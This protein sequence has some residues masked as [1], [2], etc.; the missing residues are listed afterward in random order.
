MGFLNTRIL[1]FFAGS[2]LMITKEGELFR[3][4]LEDWPRE[5]LF[6]PQ[7]GLLKMIGKYPVPTTVMYRTET[8]LKA[9]IDFKNAVAWDCDF[10]IQ[11]ASRHP[12]AISKDP[13]GYYIYHPN[14]FSGALTFSASL[15]SILRLAERVQSFSWI[16]KSIKNSARRLF[17]KIIT[18]LLLFI[19]HTF[20]L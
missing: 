7:E 4:P 10:L 6:S 13:C 2:S 3:A 12:I 8:T 9:K 14:S 17:Y 5:G 20:F 15:K 1:L 19:L 11:L 18:K 16:D